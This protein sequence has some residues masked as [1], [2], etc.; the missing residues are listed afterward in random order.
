MA[1]ERIA[2]LIKEAAGNK[3]DFSDV[4]YGKVTSISPLKV[5]V[6]GKFEIGKESL[7]LSRTVQD[8]TLSFSVPTYTANHKQIDGESVVGSLSQGSRQVTL[9]VFR[10]LRVG[11]EVSLLRGRKGQLFHIL[12]RRP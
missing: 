9:Q 12:D 2:S 5:R 1:G 10:D 8:L 7:Q 6:E 3:Q 4:L 11:D